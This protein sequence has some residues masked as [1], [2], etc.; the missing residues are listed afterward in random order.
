[1]NLEHLRAFLWLRWR[2]RVNQVK[3]AG[4]LNAVLMG[5][6]AV[7]ALFAAVGGLIGGFMVGLSVLPKSSPAVQMYV[8]DGLAVAFLFSWG[9]GILVDLQR[10]ERALA[11]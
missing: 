1:V 5:T 11:R 6:F 3:R 10:S 4:T 2:M 8:W 7:A 9:M